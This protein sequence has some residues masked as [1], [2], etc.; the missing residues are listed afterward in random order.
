[1]HD[2]SIRTGRRVP[3]VAVPF[4]APQAALGP[5][6]GE[7][8]GEAWRAAK[9]AGGEPVGPAFA[10]YLGG[11]PAEWHVD[12]GFA[13]AAA[14]PATAVPAPA[15]ATELDGGEQAVLTLRGPWTGLPAAWA[16]LSSWIEERALRPR[17]PGWES[18]VDDGG[19]RG[20]DAAVT[21]VVIPLGPAGP[22]T[23]TH[24][25]SPP[26]AWRPF[27]RIAATGPGTDRPRPLGVGVQ[28]PEVE[29]EVPW[30]ELAAMIR[31]IEDVGFDSIWVGDHLLYRV[32]GQPARGPWEAWSTLAAVAATTH[33]VALGP[34]V[35]PTGFRNPAMLAKMAA[36]V[37]EIAGGRLVLGLGAGWNEVEFRAFGFPFDHRVARFEEAF[38]IVRRLLSEGAIDFEGE[39]YSAR[40]CELL[41]RPRAGG[42]TML[43]GSL[44]ERVLR[45][46]LPYVD[47]WNAWYEDTGNRPNG[48]APLRDRVDAAS[49]DVGRDPATVE[50]TVSVLVRMPGGMG[51]IQGDYASPDAKPLEGPT[52]V[53]AETLR[54]YA[55]QGVGHVQLVLDPITVA[56]VEAFGPVL[57]LLDRP[58]G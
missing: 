24:A 31:A 53:I 30:T 4:R 48:V 49:R 22:A 41:P 37:D 7:A 54:E 52:E 32:A 20:Q 21:E 34:L 3:A 51:R 28:L 18:Y 50:R 15:Y 44:G 38:T 19:E 58:E 46:T 33:R 29:R 23:G 10:R 5:A 35:T 55:R 25:A 2:I 12:A 45:L 47:A 43:V 26:T 11:D 14:L 39:Y 36:T 6:I 27:R 13:V 42:P 16:A 57:E 40:D 17:Y 9:A 8:L 1:M 56:S